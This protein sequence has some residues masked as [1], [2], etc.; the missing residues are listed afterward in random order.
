MSS[1]PRTG[2]PPRWRRWL[3]LAL[4]LAGTAA[5]FGY[6][7]TLVDPSEVGDAFGRASLLALGGAALVTAIN[8]GVGALRWRVLLA[9]YG[10]PRRPALSRLYHAYMV[11]FFYNNYLPGGL[12]G[13]VVRGVVTRQSFGE[14][15]TTASL[16]VVLVERALGLSGLLLLVTAT[17]LVRPIAGTQ[18]VLPWSAL[19]LGLAAGG[20]VGLAAGRRLGGVLPGR[21][22]TIAASLPAIERFGPFFLA[23]GLSLVTQS[24]VSL[25][26]Y[27]VVHTVH[28]AFELG[29][30]MVI[31]PLAMAASFFPLT[32]GGA[33]VR[34]AAFVELGTRALGMAHSDAVAASLLMWLT[35]LAVAGIGGLLQLVTPFRAEGE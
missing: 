27:L 21:L 8:I 10:A 11:G 16:A 25:T 14:R 2:T 5:G 31:V 20:I 28:P 1:A 32:V 12:G 22:G 35:Q 9:A 19:G 13:D 18:G 3:W 17:Y 26:G 23:L 6:V 24:L 33:G 34:E 4:R 30:A 29:D 7:A 15:G